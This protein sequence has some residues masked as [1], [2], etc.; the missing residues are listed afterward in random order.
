[1]RKNDKRVYVVHWTED[2]ATGE[3][4]AGGQRYKDVTGLTYEGSMRV[5][6]RRVDFYHREAVI[7]GR[8]CRII[9]AAPKGMR[10][11]NLSYVTPQGRKYGLRAQREQIPGQVGEFRKFLREVGVLFL[12]FL[13]GLAFAFLVCAADYVSQPAHSFELLTVEDVL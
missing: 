7:C 3:E 2:I 1:M 5:W 8:R 10:R 9:Y 6:L 12:A 13:C 4:L 11:K